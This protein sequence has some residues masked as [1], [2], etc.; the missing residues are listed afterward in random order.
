[1][2]DKTSDLPPGII[3]IIIKG[4]YRQVRERIFLFLRKS[5]VHL[6]TILDFL[7]KYYRR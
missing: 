5:A 4:S 1:M 6:L 3:I 7:Y 2:C